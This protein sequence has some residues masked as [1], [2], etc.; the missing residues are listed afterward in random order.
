MGEQQ[1]LFEDFENEWQ[2]EWKDMPEFV[3][4]NQKP[5]QQSMLCIASYDDVKKFAELLGMRVSPKTVST[6]CPHRPLKK[7]PKGYRSEE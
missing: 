4:E 1:S 3:Q 6:W 2:K 7:N 5:V